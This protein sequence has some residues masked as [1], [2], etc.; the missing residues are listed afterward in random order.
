MKRIST[1]NIFCVLLAC[2]LSG[3]AP[4]HAQFLKKLFG[5]KEEPKRRPANRPQQKNQSTGKKPAKEK[6]KI[7]PDEIV[8]PQSVRKNRYRIDVFAALYLNELNTAK[9]VAREKL[10]EKMA[11]GLN[12]YEGIKLATDTLDFA[13]YR[14]DVYVHDIIDPK[15]T[16]EALIAAKVLDSS[17]LIIGAV[18]VN[19]ITPLA[20]FAKKRMI[21]FISAMSP[22]DGNVKDNPYFTILQPTLQTHC[23][24]LKNMLHKKYGNSNIVVYHRSNI[25]T[26]ETAYKAI[27]KDSILHVTHVNVQ[28]VPSVAML[29]A[30]FDSTETNMIVMPVLD[31]A[32]AAQLLQQ[33]HTSF[34]SYRFEVYGMPS[35]KAMP[36]LKKTDAMPN[37]AVYFTAP[38]Y[39]DPSTASGQSLATA[40]K[41][42][43]GS[44]PGEMVY[45]GYETL[46]WYTY[47]LNKYGTIF[48]A[49]IADNASAAYTRFDIKSRWDKDFNLLYQENTHLYLYRYQDGSFSVEQ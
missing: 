35:W 15:H 48:N 40:Y 4:V 28:N 16:P 23:E 45:R 19:L 26:D 29:R 20:Q 49:K 33:L 46:Y 41:R 44:R 24:W 1:L 21:N 13:G 18:P 11:P 6:K 9:P 3:S 7:Q 43:Y 37:I 42:V 34:P 36:Q 2:F 17:D 8:Y 5:G 12:F 31:G 47:L 10:P 32:Y 14:M 39:F 27:L 25:P 30:V 38:F 22:S